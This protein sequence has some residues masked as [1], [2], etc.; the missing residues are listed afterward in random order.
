MTAGTERSVG[1]VLQDIVG[2]L[3]EI[4]RSEVRLAKAEVKQE[5]SA[6]AR[7]L[8][9]LMIGAVVGIY[10][11]GFLLLALVYGLAVVIA[12]WWIAALAVGAALALIA[13]AFVSIGRH[14]MRAIDPV[15]ERTVR[16][17]KENVTWDSS[18]SR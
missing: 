16:T 5:V 15:P 17:L 1:Q 3:Q 13:F 12:S 18:Q 7:A 14:R 9:S 10:A 2:N 6:T 8:V 11:L 4:V